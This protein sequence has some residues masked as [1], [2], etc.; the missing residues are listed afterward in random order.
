MARTRN[1]YHYSVSRARK[2]AEYV[3]AK[4]IFE[5]SEAGNIDL[6]QEMKTIRNGGKNASQDLP[7]NVAGANGVEEIVNKFRE[8]YSKL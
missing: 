8:V 3:G 2:N 5:A 1:R 6:L 7:D 4:K